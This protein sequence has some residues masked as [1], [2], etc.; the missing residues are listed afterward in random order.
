MRKQNKIQKKTDPFKEREEKNYSNPVPSREFIV[1]TISNCNQ[2]VSK[3]LLLNLFSIK[4]D[5]EKE[6]F[7]R[8]LKAMERDGQLVYYP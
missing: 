1:E 7:R 2:P 8:R 6:A 5:E 4:S 3:N